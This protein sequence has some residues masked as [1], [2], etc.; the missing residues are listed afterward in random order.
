[1]TTF[2]ETKQP[3]KGFKVTSFEGDD[4]RSRMVDILHTTGV[5]AFQRGGLTLLSDDNIKE[6]MRSLDERETAPV[7]GGRYVVAYVEDAPVIHLYTGDDL[8]MIESSLALDDSPIAELIAMI[9][10]QPTTAANI[11][12]FVFD[13]LYPMDFEYGFTYELP[14]ALNM[15]RKSLL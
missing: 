10:V 14:F 13:F 5:V 9:N 15:D 2:N 3:I 7:H 1:M 6:L 4:A 8:Y 11:I 12:T